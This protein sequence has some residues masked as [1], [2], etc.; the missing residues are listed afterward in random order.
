MRNKLQRIDEL[1]G[2]TPVIELTHPLLSSR[3]Q[4]LLKLESFNPTF[5]IK[6]RTA[7]GLI[8]HAFSSGKLQPGGIVIESTS[9]NLGKSLAML[10]AVMNFKV[11]LVVDPKVPQTFKNWC[12]A[13]G[14]E[15]VIVTETDD[16]GGYQKTRIQKVRELLEH[17]KHAYWPNQYDNQ[18]NPNFHFSQTA[19]EILDLEMNSIFGAVSTGGHMTGIARYIKYHKPDVEVIA[20]DVIGSAIFGKPFKPYLLNGVGLS[21]RSANVDLDVFNKVCHVSD[22][23]AISMCHLMAKHA[24][25]LLGGSGGLVLFAAMSYLLQDYAD[26]AVCIIPDSGINYLHQIYDKGWL[27]KQQICLLNQNQLT[28]NLQYFSF[29][30]D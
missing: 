2:N 27:E 11:I 28:N 15:V 1:I 18:A 26:K 3:K 21:W 10:G 29:R 6:D 19:K 16:E 14:A 7:L 12:E 8:Q 5:S 17:Y 13:Y 22:Q 4:L 23:D 30:D 24:G 20:C 9:G 25:M